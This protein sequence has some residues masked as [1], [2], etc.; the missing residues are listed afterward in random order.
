MEP[1]NEYDESGCS[2]YPSD[3]DDDVTTARPS[4]PEPTL[5]HIPWSQ[6]PNYPLTIEGCVN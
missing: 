4:T 3:A 2:R 6:S 5:S 1:L